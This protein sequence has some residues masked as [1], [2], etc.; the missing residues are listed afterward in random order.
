MYDSNVFLLKFKLNQSGKIKVL[1][2]ANQKKGKKKNRFA[3]Q[4]F[5]ILFS[6]MHLSRSQ[7]RPRKSRKLK[8][9][10]KPIR[11]AKDRLRQS[12]KV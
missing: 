4:T 2:Q 12:K 5:M 6:A 7:Y 9:Q 10:T 11:Y 1:I 3:C 8:T